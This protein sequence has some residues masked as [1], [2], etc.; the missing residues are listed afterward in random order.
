VVPSISILAE[1]PVAVVDKVVDKG[2]TRA[3]AES[4]LQF[5]YSPAGQG[6]RPVHGELRNHSDPTLAPRPPFRNAR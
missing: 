2:G 1:L 6:T 5:I 3:A 4:F